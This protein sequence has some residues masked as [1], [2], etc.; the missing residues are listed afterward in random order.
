MG[1]IASNS[2]GDSSN[3]SAKDSI[4][5]EIKATRKMERE[6]NKKKRLSDKPRKLMIEKEI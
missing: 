4:D 6:N 1:K 2:E 5:L 3:W